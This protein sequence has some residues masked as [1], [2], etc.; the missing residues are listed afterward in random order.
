MYAIVEIDGR[1]HKV[2]KDQ[3]ILV[4][5]LNAKE[6]ESVE[7]KDVFLVDDGNKVKVGT[8]KVKGAR[9]NAKVVSH[10]KG[11]KVMV[12]KKKKRKRYRVKKGHR[13]LITKLQIENIKN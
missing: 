8:P 9:V 2:E 1:Q 3:T 10:I 5:R 13:Q 4:N 12:F 11:D 6:G 7:F